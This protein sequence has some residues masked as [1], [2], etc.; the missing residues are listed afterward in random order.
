MLDRLKSWPALMACTV[1]VA[2]CA[3]MTE[4]ADIAVAGEL[5]SQRGGFTHVAVFERGKLLTINCKDGTHI[6]VRPGE[7]NG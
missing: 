3:R 2:G 5:C 7:R 6:D 4:P 1:F